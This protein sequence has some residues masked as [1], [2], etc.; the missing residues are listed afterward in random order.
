[1]RTNTVKMGVSAH[2]L[3][4]LSE[5]NQLLG[6]E[7]ATNTKRH[8]SG[9]LSTTSIFPTPPFSRPTAPLLWSFDSLSHAPTRSNT[10]TL[11]HQSV[12]S[13]GR[14]EGDNTINKKRH[15]TQA[16]ATRKKCYWGLDQSA[17]CARRLMSEGIGA[18][19]HSAMTLPRW[20]MELWQLEYFTM[21]R[22]F[23]MG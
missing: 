7:E 20:S 19:E 14:V 17:L 12:V 3:D 23:F 9:Q 8:V 6:N 18:P 2:P 21:R 4:R 16:C 5:L 1:M 11:G 13:Q 15:A 22:L 10:L